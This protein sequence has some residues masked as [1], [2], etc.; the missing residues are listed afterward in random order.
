V[1]NA[2]LILTGSL[3]NGTSFEGSDTIRV[4]LPGK[5]VE[6]EEQGKLKGNNNAP[7]GLEELQIQAHKKQKT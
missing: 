3:A 7:K 1:G 4:M 6:H 2:T 5:H